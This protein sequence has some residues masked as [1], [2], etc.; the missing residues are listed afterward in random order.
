MSYL[1]VLPQFRVYV[2]PISQRPVT[3]DDYSV[4]HTKPE[5]SKRTSH[6][7]A[8]NTALCI[9]TP[10]DHSRYELVRKLK[11]RGFSKE[12][13]DRAVSSCEQFDYINDERTA[14]VYIRQLKRKGYGEKRI[15]L[16]LSKKGL[17]GARIQ[18]ILDE[19][20]SAN[21]EREGADR[22]LKKN[23][24][25]FERETDALKRRDK[26]YRFLHARGF[27]P[28][29]IAAAISGVDQP[30]NSQRDPELK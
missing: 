29:V 23:M 10:R 1:K 28:E 3:R 26:I 9:L 7:S 18:H 25:R 19:S 20:V 13:I 5:Q 16:E 12:D 30:D 22:I 2:L 27:S 8:L 21:D 6:K 4:K 14:R 24:K 15:R 11:Q 17:K